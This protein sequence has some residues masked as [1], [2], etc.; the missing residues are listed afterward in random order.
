MSSPTIILNNPTIT[1][2][3]AES[4]VTQGI[5]R[6]VTHGVARS[7][8]A[9]VLSILSLAV[10]LAVRL[11]YEL[12]D[13][14]RLD[15]EI[16]QLSRRN[17]DAQA[18]LAM[19]EQRLCGLME[20]PSVAERIAKMEE[21]GIRD[22]YHHIAVCGDTGTG[23]SSLI[24]AMCRLRDGDPGAAETDVIECTSTVRPYEMNDMAVVLYDTPGAGTCRVPDWDYFKNQGLYLMDI[25]VLICGDRILDLDIAIL[26]NCLRLG[27]P[28]IIVRTKSDLFLRN[29]GWEGEH[30]KAE[31]SA[32][33]CDARV[34]NALEDLR[35]YVSNEIGTVFE[36]INLPRPTAPIE[37]YFFVVNKAS[38]YKLRTTGVLDNNALDEQRLLQ[39]LHE[40]FA[41]GTVE[42]KE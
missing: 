6:G 20:P 23:K 37:D 32:I 11:K 9:G 13:R 12:F 18:R 8:A 7:V 4:G 38:L 15:D 21:L 36:K 16:I 25:V 35:R 22:G 30:D 26:R 2:I 28:F 34:A 39:L 17:E 41:R 1:L 33:S 31:S 14:P 19:L 3:T 27:I 40:R 5:A 10:P 24:N 42:E 29:L